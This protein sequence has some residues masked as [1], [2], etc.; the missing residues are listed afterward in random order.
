MDKKKHT[1][2]DYMSRYFSPWPNIQIFYHFSS[3]IMKKI[4]KTL[5]PSLNCTLSRL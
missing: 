2:N 5:Y 4:S 3:N 1:S